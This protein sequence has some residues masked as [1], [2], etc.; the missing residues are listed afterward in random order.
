MVNYNKLWKKMIDCGLNRTQLKDK[1]GVSTNVIAKL[2]KNE[3]VSLDSLAKICKVL[4]CDIG[5]VAGTN[6]DILAVNGLVTDA[7]GL[8]ALGADQ[9]DLGD[10]HGDLSADDTGLFTLLAGLH[11]AGCHVDAFHN[12]LLIGGHSLQ[13]LAFLTLILAGQ[14]NDLIVLNNIHTE[15]PP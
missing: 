14:D 4:A 10:I 13:D 11:M 6:A 5:D 1:A 3:A 15:L 8:A 2:G 7:G 12:D 9:H